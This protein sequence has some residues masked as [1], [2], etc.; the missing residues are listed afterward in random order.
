METIDVQGMQV[1]REMAGQCLHGVELVVI[2]ID[3]VISRF[4]PKL[5][6]PHEVATR[7]SKSQS[8]SERASKRW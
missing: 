6:C 2:L 3:E 8:A 1:K 7:S 5:A 4:T